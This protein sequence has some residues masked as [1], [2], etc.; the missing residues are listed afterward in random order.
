MLGVNWKSDA[1]AGKGEKSRGIQVVE[2]KGN[3]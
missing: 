1:L 2:V 3:K